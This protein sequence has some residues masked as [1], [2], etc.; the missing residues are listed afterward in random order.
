MGVV[1]A[2]DPGPGKVKRG[3]NS[4]KLQTKKQPKGN[5][6]HTV[7]LVGVLQGGVSLS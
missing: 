3:V 2:Q 7:N 1:L 4:K 6:K 5:E